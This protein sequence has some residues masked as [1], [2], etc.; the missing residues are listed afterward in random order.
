MDQHAAS[1]RR[2]LLDEEVVATAAATGYPSMPTGPDA[3]GRVLFAGDFR[4]ARIVSFEWLLSVLDT[5]TA[6]DLTIQHSSD[7][8][9]WFTLKAFTQKTAID[10]GTLPTIIYLLDSDPKPLPFIRAL[11]DMTGAPGTSTHS[12]WVNYDQLGPRGPY[13]PPGMID[14]SN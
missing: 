2:V 1:K 10:T 13:A 9:N 4:G 7:G 8:I 6:A 5:F 11:V 12:V 14:R 3:D